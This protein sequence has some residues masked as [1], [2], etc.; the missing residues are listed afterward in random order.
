MEKNIIRLTENELKRLVTEVATNV[1]NEIDAL[2]YDIDGSDITFYC[3]GTVIGGLCFNVSNYDGIYSEYNDS[4]DDFDDSIM[5]KFN[6]NK[7]IVNIEDV[8]I[9]RK[10][11]GNGFFRKIL[12]IGLDSLYQNY[13]Q[14]IL[15]ACSD[16]GFP[17]G[18]LVEIYESF[19]FVP[20]QET[21]QDGTI[22][23][24]IKSQ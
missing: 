18:K 14:F 11:Q 22:M 6:Y 4:V 13:K 7:P 19:G 10:F 24:M 15:R 21:K 16:N 17:N 2:T 3:D 9:E 20:Y 1:M 8:W 5:R 12:S 23:F